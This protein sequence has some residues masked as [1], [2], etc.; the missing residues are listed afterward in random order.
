MPVTQTQTKRMTMSDIRSKAEALGI[1]PA[2]MKKPELIHS[3]QKAEGYN[4]CFGQSRGHCSYL[5]C[6]WRSDCLKS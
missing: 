6:C 1:T 3:I 5:D 2:N 4:T